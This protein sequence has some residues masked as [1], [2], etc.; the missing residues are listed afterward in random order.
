MSGENIIF[1]KSGKMILDH[2]DWRYLWIFASPNIKKQ[3]NLQLPLNVQKT[4]MFQL[5]G[6]LPPW[7]FN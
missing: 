6:A 2:A 7:P 5:Q 4:D 3:A 1:E